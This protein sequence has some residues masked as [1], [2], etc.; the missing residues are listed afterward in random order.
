[1]ASE[2]CWRLEADCWLDPPPDVARLRE[3]RVLD[4]LGRHPRVRA[5]RA[6]ARRVRHLARHPEVGYLQRLLK[7]VVVLY[8]L[9]QKDCKQRG[10]YVRRDWRG[11][12]TSVIRRD[13]RSGSNAGIRQKGLKDWGY[14]RRDRRSGSNAG[15]RQKGLK[16]LGYIRRD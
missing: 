2:P 9:S 13:W 12:D 8:R 4:H 5:R 14:I 6:H 16:E 15:I 7:K 10:G 1:M 3:L 11:E